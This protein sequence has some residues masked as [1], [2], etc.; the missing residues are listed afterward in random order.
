LLD[1]PP[2][3]P[4]PRIN[5]KKERCNSHNARTPTRPK[6]GKNPGFCYN[7]EE[8]EKEGRKKKDNK[9]PSQPAQSAQPAFVPDSQERTIPIGRAK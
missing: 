2:P 1:P 8:G 7:G 5:T 6:R 9:R 4:P 3:T